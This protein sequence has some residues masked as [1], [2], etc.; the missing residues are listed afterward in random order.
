[1]CIEHTWRSVRVPTTASDYSLTTLEK[2]IRCVHYLC[3][4]ERSFAEHMPATVSMMGEV[5]VARPAR[6][7]NAGEIDFVTIGGGVHGLQP[8]LL[9]ALMMTNVTHRGYFTG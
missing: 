3:A 4:R 2:S 9:I 7:G 5:I 1:M 6:Y 8:C